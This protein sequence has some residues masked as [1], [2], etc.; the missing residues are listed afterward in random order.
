MITVHL[1]KDLSERMGVP[2]S[3]QTFPLVATLGDLFKSLDDEI[4]GIF[5]R[6]CQSDGQ[7]RRH[8]NVFVGEENARTDGGLS[9]KLKDGD[10]VWVIQS[11][12]GG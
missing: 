1:P 2:K 4:P 10:E 3:T 9:T 7:I 5:L 6:I 12:S 11:V 8:L